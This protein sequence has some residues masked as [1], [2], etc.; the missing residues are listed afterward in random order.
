MVIFLVFPGDRKIKN[1]A[2][3][4][5]CQRRVLWIDQPI[6]W[7]LYT[8]L[9]L[10][11]WPVICIYVYIEE[12]VTHRGYSNV[13]L[14]CALRYCSCAEECLVFH[15]ARVLVS[16]ARRVASWCWVIGLFSHTNGSR[17][18]MMSCE[19]M[20]ADIH[21]CGIVSLYRF[22]IYAYIHRVAQVPNEIYI[23]PCKLCVC[24]AWVARIWMGMTYIYIWDLLAISKS[25]IVYESTNPSQMYIQRKSMR[26]CC[27]IMMHSYIRVYICLK[28]T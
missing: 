16:K 11:H 2:L 28:F 24:G 8:L 5:Y 1:I 4:K 10:V 20:H 25:Y 12:W 15:A 9:A 19:W 23:Y 7:Y 13:R 21:I 3:G 22:E 6:R 27:E 17:E 26:G 18:K 14:D